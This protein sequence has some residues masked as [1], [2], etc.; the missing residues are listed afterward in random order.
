M[1]SERTTARIV[2]VLFI[3]ATATAV[4]SDL[5][6]RSL[7]DDPDYVAEF[8]ANEGRVIL[9]ALFEVSLAVAVVAIAVL[10]FPFLRRAH[11]GWALGYVGARILEGTIVLAGGVSSLLLLTLSQEYVGSGGSDVTAFQAS[12]VLLLEAR[13]WTDSLGTTIV[14]G[15]GA[16]ILYSLLY[17]AR[18]VPGWLSVWG[19]VGA[20]MVL[21]AGLLR[22]YGESPTSMTS[23]LLTL[24]IGINEMV[25]AVWLIVRGFDSRRIVSEAPRR[26]MHGV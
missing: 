18:L 11:E 14:F 10:L 2:G 22:M 19:F 9:A 21:V 5:L 20:V 4:M 17:Q 15:L 8:A 26:V 6:L 24:P 23:I 12:G 3:V 1:H 13:E 25:L 7:R 16:L